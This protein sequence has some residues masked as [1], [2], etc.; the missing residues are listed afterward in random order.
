MI[1]APT[2]STTLTAWW[3]VSSYDI[4]GQRYQGAS[5]HNPREIVSTGCA[6]EQQ[7]DDYGR[8][9]DSSGGAAAAIAKRSPCS[10]A[11][12]PPKPSSTR[13]RPTRSAW[14]G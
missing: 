14:R 6:V 5:R 12:R 8:E 10:A 13:A 11:P 3:M 4:D 2:A 1:E 7:F 9:T